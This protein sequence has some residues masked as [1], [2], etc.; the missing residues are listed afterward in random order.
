VFKDTIVLVTGAASGIGQEIARQFVE[1]GA[2]VVGA[3]LNEKNLQETSDRF[4]DRF[5]AKLCDISKGDQI[6]DLCKY[7]EGEFERLDVLVNN[8]GAGHLQDPEEIEEEDFYF[9]YDILLKGPVLLVK[10][11][12]PLLRKSANPSVINI[13]SIAARINAGKHIMYATAK[14]ALEKF[15]QHLTKDL[16][17]IRFNC[18]LPGVIDTPIL[19]NYGEENL[20]AI[21]ELVAS[22]VPCGRVG[23]TADIANCVLFVCSDKAT[24]ING[25]SIVIDGGHMQAGDW[26]L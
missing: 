19:K 16:P 13:A 6:R 15:T 24:Y 25:A 2:T 5:I 10:H 9:N 14:A 23:T 17:G 21:F 3:D 22:K 20:P 7:I 26:G 11:L 8:A 4:G 12:A 18:I 1:E